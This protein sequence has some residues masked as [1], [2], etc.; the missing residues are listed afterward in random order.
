[1]K[2]KYGGKWEILCQIIASLSLNTSAM[3]R[4]NRSSRGKALTNIIISDLISKSTCVDLDIPHGIA[5]HHCKHKLCVLT[6]R[7]VNKK[8][9][10]KD[11][12]LGDLDA[13]SYGIIIGRSSLMPLMDNYDLITHSEGILEYNLT[14]LLI[15]M[16]IIAM[17]ILMKLV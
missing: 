3:K 9:S 11:K 12:K 14:L 16:R 6:H 7:R 15:T 13:S 4:S 1:M 8:L 17:I 5:C 2:D 10:P